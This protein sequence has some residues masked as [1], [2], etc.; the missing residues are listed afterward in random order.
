MNRTEATT[1]SHPGAYFEVEMLGPRIARVV[2]AALVHNILR[3][4]GVHRPLLPGD[5]VRLDHDPGE[6][7]ALPKLTE[8]VYKAEPRFMS[9]VRC[10][11]YD[12]VYRLIA[13]T[14][15][16]GG[17]VDDMPSKR[18]GHKLVVRLVHSEAIDVPA[19]AQ[20]AGLTRYVAGA[21]PPP[22]HLSKVPYFEESQA[23]AMVA[24][25]VVLGAEV[26][27]VRRKPREVVLF[28]GDDIDVRKIADAAGVTRNPEAVELDFRFRRPRPGAVPGPDWESGAWGSLD[29]RGA[30][31]AGRD[32][33]DP[34]EGSAE[35]PL[36]G[37]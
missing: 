26:M 22:I 10:Y 19:V 13:L 30:A 31:S 2:D 8:V 5:I 28:H 1:D 15:V 18:R 9:T 36:R 27:Y 12:Q 21:K 35:G 25:A 16:L 32:A 37:Q 20:A 14:A 24:L 29:K 34:A 4:S 6:G 23:L 7:D 11:S 33:E 17:R 3:D